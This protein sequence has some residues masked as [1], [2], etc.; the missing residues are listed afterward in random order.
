MHCPLVMVL[1]HQAIHVAIILIIVI[2]IIRDG[3]LFFIKGYLFR[4]KIVRKL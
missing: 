3:P 2:I 4:K 1:L